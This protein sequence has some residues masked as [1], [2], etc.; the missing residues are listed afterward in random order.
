MEKVGLVFLGQKGGGLQILLSSVFSLK[1]ENLEVFVFTDKRCAKIISSHQY[2]NITI[3]SYDFPHNIV[4][5]ARVDRIF[6]NTLKL[7]YELW[8]TN[9][10]LI[11]QLMPSPFDLIVD[12]LSKFRGK[13][14]IVRVIHDFETHIG[15]KWPTRKALQSR[16]RRATTLITFSQHVYNRIDNQKKEITRFK[17][18]SNFHKHEFEVV[19]KD[20]LEIEGFDSPRLL[21]IGRILKYKGIE[22]LSKVAAVNPKWKFIIA[23]EG[24]LGNIPTNFYPINRWLSNTEF[25]YLID[26]ADIII[27]P[28]IEASQSGTIPILMNKNKIIVISEVGGLRE[29]VYGYDRAFVCQSGDTI[30]LEDSIS[31]AMQD[32]ELFQTKIVSEN[33]K[34]SDDEF[35]IIF[36][37]YIS[38]RVRR[39]ADHGKL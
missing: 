25:E 24:S 29:Q 21:F 19:G 33:Q 36:R 6:W 22:T 37:E 39:I 34:V 38:Q 11:V 14:N 35:E 32:F 17:L 9:P 4:S 1:N 18:P 7:S 31:R 2:E 23:G 27:F 5:L 3:F 20:C 13:N 30:G 8:K 26:K 10:R 28:Y 16:I 12:H 15:E